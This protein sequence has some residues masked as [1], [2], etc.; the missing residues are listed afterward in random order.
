V[1]P[2]DRSLEAIGADVQKA[3]PLYLSV[4]WEAGGG[5]SF[6]VIPVNERGRLPEQIPLF[7]GHTGP[8]LDTDWYVKTLL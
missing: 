5:G 7:K 1:L 2:P 4:N 3:N 6:A 8:V